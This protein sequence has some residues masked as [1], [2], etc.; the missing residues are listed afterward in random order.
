MTIKHKLLILIP[1]ALIL[2]GCGQADSQQEQTSE[3]KNP[4]ANTALPDIP[5]QQNPL[6]P[7]TMASER[8]TFQTSDGV[9]IVGDFATS[10][11]T[12]RAVLLL[13]MMP[14]VRQSFQ[15]LAS[16]L[17]KNGFAALAI[18]LRGHGESTAQ[19]TTTLDYQKFS[20][21]EHQGSRLDVDAAIDFLKGK[22]FE[23]KNI[24][25]VGASIGANLALDAMKR[26]VSIKF[27]VLLSPGLDYRGVMAEK[28][29]KGLT[30]G[31]KVWLIAA[32][33]DQYSAQSVTKLQQLKPASSTM[34]IYDGEDHGTDLFESQ[35]NLINDI[36]KFLSQ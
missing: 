36:I 23:E 33:Q 19:G 6:T 9:T 29:M 12:K 11:N 5:A 27:G 22:G 25:V 20:P 34:T 14:A 31:Q 28:A 3:P 7:T 10:A 32:E 1:I 24:S 16:E 21:R 30:G 15:P 17:N 35:P 13:H 18:D 4:M 8:I 2:S 26:Y